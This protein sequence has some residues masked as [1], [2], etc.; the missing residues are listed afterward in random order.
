MAD[1]NS[2][3]PD[4]IR[5]VEAE[6]GG[7]VQRMKRLPGGNRR[8]AWAIDV[9]GKDGPHALF[10]RYDPLDPATTGDVFTIPREASVYRLLAGSGVAVPRLVA[11]HG[12]RQA[13]L[14]ERIRGDSDF[15]RLRDIDVKRAVSLDVVRHLA[16]LHGLDTKPL[17]ASAP[18]LALRMPVLV[19]REIATWEALYRK[20]GSVDPLI[21]FGFRWLLGNVPGTDEPAVVVH[22]DAGPGNF[23]FEGSEVTALL[24]WELSHFGDPMEDLAW[25]SMR[26]NLEPFPDFPAC[27]AEY[28]HA[29]GRTID[30]E[31][32]LYCRVLVE[33]KVAVIRHR[34]AG[35]DLANSLISRAVCRRLLVEAIAAAVGHSLPA[36]RPVEAPRD[37]KGE[38]FDTALSY[39]REI[40]TPAITDP[41]AKRKAKSV[42]RIIKY[43][44]EADR[45][46]IGMEARARADLEALMGTE[47][48][49]LDS[50]RS[51]LATRIRDAS[52]NDVTLLDHFS[53]EV[54]RDI[55]LMEPALGA[56][57][58]RPFPPISESQS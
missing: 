22:G 14:T 35:E 5:W 48:V 43:L 40:V 2:L 54:G 16:H 24:D 42:A 45:L 6:A 47:I 37:R 29:A 53:A 57:A 38:Y 9:R 4:L 11:L 31:R 19:R 18:D 25:L 15:G 58:W 33:W 28:E 52:F 46:G 56:L 3:E 26:T 27:M 50:A 55:Q 12:D 8:E 7:V 20:T 23:L 36:Y 10:L 49:D 13:M 39:L 21:E 32:L 51:L 34:N 30:F 44:Q 1:R 41:V 17:I